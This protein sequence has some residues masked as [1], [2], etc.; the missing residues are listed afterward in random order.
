MSTLSLLAAR[1]MSMRETPGVRE[2][3]LQLRAQLQ[4]LVQQLRVVLVG[5]PARPPGLVEPEPEAVRMNFLTHVILNFDVRTSK[6][7]LR[8]RPS[9]SS[10]DALGPL[11]VGG[12]G[13][14]H[15]PLGDLHRQVRHALDH[16]ERPA[17]R[18]RAHPLHA[19]PLIGPAPGDEQPIDV[20]AEPVLL[21]HVGDRRPQRLLDV[22][23][24][25]LAREPQRRQRARDVHAANLRR[26]RARPSAPRCGCTARS[27]GRSPSARSLGRGPPPPGAPPPAGAA[28]AICA[29]FSAF[30]VWPLKNRVGANSPSLCPTMFSVMYTGMNFLPLCTAIVWPTISGTTVDRRDQVL[31]TFF[32]L[33]RFIASTFSSR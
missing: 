4:I 2:A 19:R 10:S 12:R 17:H 14:L 8:P 5:V 15:R 33:S 24:D 21:L 20:A 6:F 25:D 16:A 27:R 7:E 22:A 29:A 32:S 28:A 31:M 23:R 1:S 18:R 3:R 13:G 30:V 26:A 11:A 9:P